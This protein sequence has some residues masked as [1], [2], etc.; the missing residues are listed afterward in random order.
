MSKC[1][2]WFRRDLRIEDHPAL[3]HASEQG[4]DVVAVYLHSFDG[5]LELNEGAASQWWLHHALVDFQQRV[6]SLGGSLLILESD[7][8]TSTLQALAREYDAEDIFW[9]RRYEPKAVEL[10]T[11]LK[12]NLQD[13]GY[14]VESFNTSLFNEPHEVQNKS[15]KPFQVFTP[16]WKHC[17]QKEV[18]E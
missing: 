16:F 18:I 17:V 2:L 14:R 7:N 1:L 11:Q 9:S 13:A 4:M 5:Q 8:P 12:T 15:G 6:E 3:L 10:D